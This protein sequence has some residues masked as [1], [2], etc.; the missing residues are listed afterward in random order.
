MTRKPLE[1]SY[2]NATSDMERKRALGELLEHHYDWIFRLSLAELGNTQDALDVTQEILIQITKSIKRFRYNSKFSTWAFVIVKRQIAYY[3]KR[4]KKRLSLF[5]SAELDMFE[6]SCELQDELVLNK[7]E[8]RRLLAEV[9][10]LPEKQRYVVYLHYFEDL[11]VEQVAERI[12]A[13]AGT[14]KTHLFRARR[15]IKKGLEG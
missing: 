9:R 15:S 3:R 5:E 4:N 1:E 13:S 10:K 12:S 2:K 11:S 6:S 14:V 7:E 8:G